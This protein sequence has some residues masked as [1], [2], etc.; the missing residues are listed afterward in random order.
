MALLPSDLNYLENVLVTA[1]T[2]GG[3]RKEVYNRV[4]LVLLH[5]LS[6]ALHWAN[7]SFVP[8]ICFAELVNPHVHL[9]SES[10]FCEECFTVSLV[11]FQQMKLSSLSPFVSVSLCSSITICF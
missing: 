1:H 10:D 11:H 5:I 2:D 6:Q 7:Y 4:Q 8:I 3:G 9:G